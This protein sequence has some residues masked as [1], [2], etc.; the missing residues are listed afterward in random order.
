MLGLKLAIG[1]FLSLA[2]LQ[3]LACSYPTP[4]AFSESLDKATS[5]FVFRLRS[6]E[7]KRKTYGSGAYREWVEGRIQVRETL[8]GAKPAFTT[9][10]FS[11]QQCGGLRLDV[12]HY[13][14]IA[15][16]QK[17][18]ALDLVPS[19]RSIIDI[20]D[21]YD[22]T[23]AE[24]NLQSDLVAPIAGFIK[25]KPLPADFPPASIA[26]RTSSLPYPPPQSDK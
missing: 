16:A 5:V 23:V 19:D 13:F 22:E 21:Y 25:G 26:Q 9:V 17:G 24:R 7:L 2:S 3:A 10:T 15:T 4:K 8:K 1:V 20:S 18:R 12:G 6:A 11:T 14:V